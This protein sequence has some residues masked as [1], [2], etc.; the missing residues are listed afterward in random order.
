MT[1]IEDYR[2]R[3]VA[4]LGAAGFHRMAYREWGVDNSRGTV[5]CV[6]GLTRNAS[7]FDDLAALLADDGWRVICP[8]MAGR[9]DS[10]WL[11][12]PQDYAIQQYISDLAALLARIDSEELH[13]VGTSMG[14]ILGM[15]MAGLPG[16]GVASLFLNDIGPFVPKAAIG[17][18]DDHLAEMPVY[19]DLEAAEVALRERYVAFGA[20]D[21]EAWRRVAVGSTRPV[22]GGYQLS[23]DPAIKAAFSERAA[24]DIELWEVWD[25]L[26]LP[27]A[28][29]RGADSTLLLADTAAEMTSR[30]PSSELHVSPGAGHAPWLKQEAETAIVQD[31]L[32]RR[33]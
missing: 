15:V 12:R 8:D 10:D 20:L 32:D 17:E 1:G 31:W 29:L 22:D 19:P 25:A 24:E 26:D 33:G 9:G 14:G 11:S 2:L 23:Y 27:V 4:C 5:V 7:D 3:R 16:N 21:D 6:H 28:T 18:I 13:W 30:G